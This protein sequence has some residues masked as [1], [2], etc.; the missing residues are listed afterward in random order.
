MNEEELASS[1][2]PEAGEPFDD[3]LSTYIDDAINAQQ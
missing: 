3:T 1:T 2:E